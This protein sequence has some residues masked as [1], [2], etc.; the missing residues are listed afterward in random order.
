[1]REPQLVNVFR[2]ARLPAAAMHVGV[3][4]PRHQV[5]AGAVDFLG[6]L[7]GPA[8]L[9]DRHAR[10]T[11]ARHVGDAV[12]L[13]HDIDRT[14]RLGAGAVDDSYVANHQTIERALAF[15]GLASGRLRHLLCRQGDEGAQ[16]DRGAQKHRLGDTHFLLQNFT[17]IADGK[18][19]R[20]EMTLPAGL[21]SGLYSIRNA[22]MGSIRIARRAGT[23]F[24]RA[25]AA[26][27]APM[28]SAHATGSNGE[29]P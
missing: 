18:K 26:I 14:A 1:M 9:V 12:V 7:G 6:A 15:A 17:S 5:E 19:T 20:R 28:A 4:E 11:D 21:Y 23:K 25:E 2:I 27:M 10:K 8:A 13:H 16:D 3:N 24:A 29:M 22:V